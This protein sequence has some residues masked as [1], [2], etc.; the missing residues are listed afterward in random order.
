MISAI[1]IF[2][3]VCTLAACSVQEEE[4][5]KRVAGMYGENHE[6][7]DSLDP[8]VHCHNGTF[9]GLVYD[10]VISYKGIP[11]ALPPTGDRRWQPPVPAPDQE[12]VFEAYYFGPSPIQTEWPS[13]PGSYYPQS[14]D[15]LTLNV[16]VNEANQEEDKPV[17]VFFHGGSYGWGAVSDPIYDGH[18]LIQKFDDIILVT[19]EFRSGILGFIDLSTVEGGE[20]YQESGNLGL[21]D[22]KCALEWIHKNIAGFGGDPGNVTI[23]GESSG[24]GSVS[25]LPLMNDTE[26]LFQRIIAESGSVALTYSKEEC[27]NLTKMLLEETGCTKMEEL[28]ALSEEDLR[29]ANEKLNDYNNFPERDGIVIPLDL[30]EACRNVRNTDLLI[31][32]NA[33]EVRYWVWEMEYTFPGLPG[34]PVYDFMIPVMYENNIRRLSDDEKN[35]TEAFLAMQEGNRTDQLTE[36]YNEVL[37]RIPALQ[38][39]VNYAANGNNVYTYYWTYPCAEESI[40]A[41]HAVELAYVFNNPSEIIYTGGKY[42]EQLAD[43]V[44]QMWIGFVRNGNPSTGQYAWDSYD[45]KER[46]TMVLGSRIHME[47][48]IKGENRKRIEPLLRHYFNGCYAQLDYSVPQTY[49]IIL[50]VTAVFALCIT[51]VIYR[52]KKNR[53]HHTDRGRE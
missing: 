17:M 2:F 48:D 11:Y 27:Q 39:A 30:Y 13:E 53:M 10:G 16:W 31:G 9:V 12:G 5:K 7:T 25:L 28:I 20:E 35:E 24:A 4:M 8:A 36:F 6:I 22:Q 26:G 45:G 1:L 38:Q 50:P 29:K 18:N 19:V 44:Q 41:C 32:T 14:E 37:F 42:D 46:R 43:A 49:R 47:S 33:D 15:C 51:A 52:Q 21:L 40:G 3:T 34:K 23:C